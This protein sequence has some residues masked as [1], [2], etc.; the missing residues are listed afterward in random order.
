[1]AILAS[2]STSPLHQILLT[3]VCTVGVGLLMVTGDLL[4]DDSLVLCV[5]THLLADVIIRAL[6]CASSMAKF[7]QCVRTACAL[8]T[9]NAE[10]GILTQEYLSPV[11]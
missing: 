4:H 5:I 3:F 7:L 11:L 6:P 9:A 2:K 1:M 10:A 8:H